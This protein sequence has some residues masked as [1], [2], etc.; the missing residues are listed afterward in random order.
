MPARVAL[1]V[2]FSFCVGMENLWSSQ[3]GERFTST[4]TSIWL[5]K[6]ENRRNERNDRG[7]VSHGQISAARFLFL[8]CSIL[9]ELFFHDDTVFAT[10]EKS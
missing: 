8:F 4:E 2:E 5:T 9:G 10:S 1:A 6:G 3:C 7:T